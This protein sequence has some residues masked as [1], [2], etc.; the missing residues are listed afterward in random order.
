M[1]GIFIPDITVEMFRNGCLEAI[2]ELM[3]E[4]E[5]YDIEYDPK[6]AESELGP[7]DFCKHKDDC[8][9]M[10]AFCPAERRI[11]DGE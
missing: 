1:K 9:Y 3:A 7:C 4:G 6:S 5:I 2:E 8:G 10:R 11:D